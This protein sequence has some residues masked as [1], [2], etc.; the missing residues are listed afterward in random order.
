V[1]VLVSVGFRRGNEQFEE[2]LFMDLRINNE[3]IILDELIT[4]YSS[5][6]GSDNLTNVY[7]SLKPS[8][9][10]DAVG[11]EDWLAKLDEVKGFDGA[12]LDTE[13]DHV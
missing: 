7:A 6:V 13:R 8:G 4:S 11:V 1:N 3:E 5:A 12:R 10:F 2:G 9:G